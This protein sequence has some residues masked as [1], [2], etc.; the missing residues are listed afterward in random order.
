MLLFLILVRSFLPC[1]RL[2][3]SRVLFK[4]EILGTI[5]LTVFQRVMLLENSLDSKEGNDLKFQ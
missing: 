5:Q 4:S 3:I 1:K 2:S